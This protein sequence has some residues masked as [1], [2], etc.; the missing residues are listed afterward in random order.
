VR[1]FVVG[2]T[3]YTGREVVRVL[4][5]RGIPTVAHVR[6]DSPSLERARAG[7][8]LTGAETD[9]TA[10]AP[11][12]MHATLSRVEPTHV[13]ALL[14]ITRKRAKQRAAA[15][16]PPE[17]YESVD[18]GLTAMLLEATRRAIPSAKFIYLSALGATDRTGNE[19]LRVRGRI[20]R[21][22]RE[23]GLAALIVRPSFITGADREEDRHT[24]RVAAWVADRVLGVAAM[25]GAR[26]LRQRF[27]ART[28]TELAAEMVTLAL[29]PSSG[30]R[31]VDGVDLD[32]A[33]G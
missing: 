5:E 12:A 17:S 18:Y 27:R 6:G 28:G 9:S 10:W 33:R 7:F 24:E 29:E 4:R 20:E 31:V 21:E 30:V 25:F 23:S 1:A 16:A 22:I 11:A 26:A 3:G 2:A 19:Y 13:F 32:G 15:G 8:A 14:G